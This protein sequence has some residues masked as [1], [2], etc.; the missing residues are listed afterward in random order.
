M[1]DEKQNYNVENLGK[2]KMFPFY[3]QKKKNS[4]Q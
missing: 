3:F 4:I 1:S 2:Y